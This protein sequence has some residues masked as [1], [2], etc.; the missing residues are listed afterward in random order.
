MDQQ[1]F[2]QQLQIVLDPKKG[3]VKTATNVLQNEFYKQPQSLLFLI[4][5]IISH[6]SSE[7][8]QLAASQAKPLVSKH[9][10]K[11]PADHR[12][13]ARAQ[14]LQATLSEESSLARHAS[15]RLISSIAKVDLNDGEWLELPG[16]LV[17]AAT[18]SKASERA[19]GVY[20]L[21]SIL[22]TMGDGFSEKFKDLF[23]LFGKTIKDP[24][25]MEV[26]V[27]TMLALSKMALVIDAEDDQASVKAF[28]AIFPSM[29]TV[30]KDTID[31]GNEEHTML[32]FE[33]LA[34]LLGYDYQLMSKHFQDLVVFMNQIAINT[35]MPA[36]TRIQA[37]SFLM[38][39]IVYRRL[40]VQG[41][42]MGEPLMTSM[43][44]IITEIGSNNEDD[45]LTPAKSA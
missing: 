9:W 34:N 7:L 14:L 12:H 31:A 17:Q 29:V 1:R 22:D 27:N 6:D 39:C 42:K 40:K 36:D 8:K 25:S 30:L 28:Q 16:F 2:L 15:S 20:L 33:V 38:Q 10:T 32:A 44:Q 11:V 4:Q 41:A 18:S 19:V 23:A 21:Y 45:D 26:R 43:L 35:N 37:I 3:N 24:E 5:L 13:A